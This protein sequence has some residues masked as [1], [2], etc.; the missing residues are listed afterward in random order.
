MNGRFAFF[1]HMYQPPFP[2]QTPEVLDRIINNSYIPL[3][4]EFLKSG[5][6]LTVN[7]NASLTEMLDGHET[8]CKVIEN[9]RQLSENHQIEFVESGAYHP[10]LPLLT[11]DYIDTQIKLNHQINSKLLG[12]SYKPV[13]FFPPELALN[14]F[15][16]KKIADHG[17][18]YTLASEPTYENVSFEKI[19][20]FPHK[21]KNFFIVRRNRFLSNDIAFKSYTTVDAVEQA[22]R[23]NYFPVIGMDWETFGE[24]HSDYIPF[25]TKILDKLPSIPV[26][27][28]VEGMIQED[29]IFE[30]PVEELKPS[31]W[32]TNSSDINHGIPFPLWDNPTNPLHQ[33]ILTL[34]DILDQSIRFIDE[35]ERPIDF[36]KSQQSCQLWWASEGRFGPGLI[37]RAISYQVSTLKSVK[38]VAESYSK[39]KKQA[40]EGLLSVAEKIMTKIN[41]L[42]EV[43]SFSK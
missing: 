28:Y 33:L 38:Q 6:R 39:E 5:H 40:L 18:K 30:Y 35:K 11:S 14:G 12:S 21:K 41:Y 34:M 23:L 42:V 8:G 22:F 37:K 17:Y 20:F 29:K 31:S 13:G 43:K 32:S 2:V 4:T 27:E 15:V 24:H 7:I 16:A 1:L 26:G 25:L 10:I 3:T 19:P 9:L 36:Y